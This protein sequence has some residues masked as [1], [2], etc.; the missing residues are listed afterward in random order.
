MP[1]RRQ[2]TIQ[3]KLTRLIMLTC[4]VALSVALLL[5][6]ANDLN[7]FRSSL[8]RDLTA[9]AGVIAANATSAVEFDD[10]AVAAKT[11]HS[12]AANPNVMAATL[13]TLNGQVFTNYVRAGLRPEPAPEPGP[14]GYRF[15]D[16]RLDLFETV[17]SNGERLGTLH[18]AFDMGVMHRLFWRY[19]GW[20]A[21]TLGGALAVAYIVSGRLQKVVSGPVLAL[22]QTA[23][24]VAEESD[25]SIRAHKRT[26]DEVGFLIDR[27][28]SMLAQIE[29]N[30]KE[31][32][33]IN[34]QLHDSEQRAQAATEAKSQFLANMSHELRTPLNAIIGYSEMLQE[35][36]QELGQEQFLRDLER[37]HIAAKHQLA[38]I[39]DILDLSKIEA[40]RMTL[41]VETLSV[42]SLVEEVT[43]TMRPLAG[44]NNNTLQIEYAPDVGTMHGDVTKVRQTLF[45][46]LTNACKFTTNGVVSL[47]VKRTLASPGPV[48]NGQTKG[49]AEAIQFTGQRQ[50][51]WHVGGASGQVVSAL[52]ASGQL[53]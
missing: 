40:G 18:L 48:P 14:P 28:N 23:R 30:E 4:G 32:R 45:N 27:F 21:L 34:Q 51:D 20:S 17:V 25:Y 50:W 41:F 6:A 24:R 31:L 36:M 11:L 46:L 7:T 47:K 44:K 52:H 13:Y 1:F 53:D 35:E 15:H 19:A 37:I 3:A 33:T 22:A 5:F 12:L 38:L 9:L 16:G 42:A 39:N 26:D 29:R 8:L 43:T 49:Q 10:A 2:T